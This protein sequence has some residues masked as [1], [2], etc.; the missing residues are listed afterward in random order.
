MSGDAAVREAMDDF[1]AE[2]LAVEAAE[3]A[4]APLGAEVEG[5]E[6]LVHGSDPQDRRVAAN[7]LEST[8]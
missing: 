6:F 4:A 2:A 1:E 7:V 5:E 3:H 8:V